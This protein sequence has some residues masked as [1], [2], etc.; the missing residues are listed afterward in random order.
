MFRLRKYVP[1][2]VLLSLLIS[3][4]APAA[5]PTTAP[6]PTAPPLPRCH[7]RSAA[8][9]CP[10]AAYRCA[11][12][13]PTATKACRTKVATFIWSQEFDSLNPYITAHVVFHHH[14]SA[15]E[16]LGLELRR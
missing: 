10:R 4:C 5:T 3:A 6:Q 9:C 13:E 8:H 12:R 2:I 14:R 15:L 11:S 7:N 16:L 1:L